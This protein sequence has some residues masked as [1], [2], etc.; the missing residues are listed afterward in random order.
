MEG[1]F[2]ELNA[3]G[4]NQRCRPAIPGMTDPRGPTQRKEMD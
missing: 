1:A 3:E 4:G 2:L